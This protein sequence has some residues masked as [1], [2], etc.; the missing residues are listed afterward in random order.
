MLTAAWLSQMLSDEFC[1]LQGTVTQVSDR[2]WLLHDWVRCCQMDFIY[3]KAQSYKCQIDVDCCM[4]ES[5]AV[6]W[7]LCLLQGTVPRVLDICW[8]L[9]DWV[10]CC[11]MDF[12]YCKVQ[13]HKCQIYVDCCMTESDAVRW[14]L[15]TARYSHTSV[16]YMLTATW[17]S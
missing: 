14:I 10:R 7:I 5:D 15:S 2:C 11:Q 6:R 13:S 1:L 3:C 17:L 8:M 4:T 12:V 16:R 9:H